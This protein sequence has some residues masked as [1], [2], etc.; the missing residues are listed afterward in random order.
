MMAHAAE[1]NL[2]AEVRAVEAGHVAVVHRSGEAAW[3]TSY[4]VV[5]DTYRDKR[6][7]VVLSTRPWEAGEPLSLICTPRGRMAYADD[8]LMTGSPEPGVVPCMHA[9]V[10]ARRLEREGLATFDGA[11][12]LATEALADRPSQEELDAV[13]D[14]L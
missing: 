14:G 1:R 10:V 7:E 4:H 3:Q 13:F 11:R 6:Y 5:S 2:A 8:H 9:A 12:W